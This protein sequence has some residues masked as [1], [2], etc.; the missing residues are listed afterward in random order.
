MAKKTKL[1]RNFSSEHGFWN[2]GLAQ[3]IRKDVFNRY[4]WHCKDRK[5]ENDKAAFMENYI[6]LKRIQRRWKEEWDER[7]LPFSKQTHLWT[8]AWNQEN[9]NGDWSEFFPVK[10]NDEGFSKNY[11]S[12]ELKIHSKILNKNT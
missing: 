2:R 7:C 4:Y 6:V 9:N 12:K 1:F 3:E 11:L 10:Q 5:D 8:E